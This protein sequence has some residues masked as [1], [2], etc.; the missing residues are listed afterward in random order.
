MFPVNDAIG[1]SV[2]ELALTGREQSEQIGDRRYIY[3]RDY[4][5]SLTL[6]DAENVI[7]VHL[8][9]GNKEGF[10][11]YD[12]IVPLGAAFEMS[13]DVLRSH[14]GVPELISEAGQIAPVLG[15]QPAWDRFRGD[16]FRL[17][18]EYTHDLQAVGMFTIM[19]S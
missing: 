16:G 17:H 12:H 8:Y 6:D 3:S 7:G 19:P 2:R 13:R 9:G 14:L 15:P 1:K 18:A 5:F 10:A 4:G 11:R